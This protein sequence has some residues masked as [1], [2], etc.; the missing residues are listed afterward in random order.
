MSMINI[1]EIDPVECG[2]TKKKIT[3]I[4][5]ERRHTNVHM[6][7]GFCM[8]TILRPLSSLQT[9]HVFLLGDSCMQ[10]KERHVMFRGAGPSRFFAPIPPSSIP[11]SQSLTAPPTA[12]FSRSN[13]P[14]LWY[15]QDRLSGPESVLPLH[16]RP[17]LLPTTCY[18]RS[19]AT[20]KYERSRSTREH[21]HRRR[22]CRLSS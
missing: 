20:Q 19:P 6:I 4:V 21:H 17:S 3:H 10:M 9:I 15:A 5:N 22:A 1:G 18:N 14:R 11:L 13:V 8:T 12:C 16:K 2:V 7:H